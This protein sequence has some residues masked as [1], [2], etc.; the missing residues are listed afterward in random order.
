MV[1]SIF[2][3]IT[4]VAGLTGSAQ[5]NPVLSCEIFV[6]PGAPLYEV[7]GVAEGT[8]GVTGR[9]TLSVRR[10][11][12]GNVSVSQQGGRF[13][14]EGSGRVIVSRSFVSADERGDIQA[15]LALTGMPSATDAE[16]S[17]DCFTE[18]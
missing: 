17:F 5:A 4:V 7:V 18:G 3:S 2:Y 16:K 8:P 11:V 13:T 6:L 15:S 14:I 10:A 12:G 9:Y 1:L